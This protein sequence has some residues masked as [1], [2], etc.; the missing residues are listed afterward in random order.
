[1]KENGLTE[2]DMNKAQGGIADGASSRH[3]QAIAGDR[4]QGSNDRRLHSKVRNEFGRPVEA[5]Q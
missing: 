2:D 5:A 1:M 3:V 4:D